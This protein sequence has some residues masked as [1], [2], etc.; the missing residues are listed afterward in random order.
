MPTA[1]IPVTI[2]PEAEHLAA[3]WG[4]RAELDRMIEGTK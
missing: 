4:I 3:E 2:T 1:T